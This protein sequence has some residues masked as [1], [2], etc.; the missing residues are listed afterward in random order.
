MV[1]VARLAG[2]RGEPVEGDGGDRVGRRG[3]VVE[4]VLLAGD[5]RLAVLRRR[6]HAAVVG[7]PEAVEED[8]GDG[9]SPRRSSGLAGRLGQAGEGVDERG[10]VGGEGVVAGS[11][12]RRRRA[13]S[14]ASAR[15][16]RAARRA[17]SGRR[18]PRPRST[19][20][21]RAAA[22]ASAS[23][24][25][26]S[27]F[28]SVST[29]SSSP[30]RGRCS[31][32]SNS[33]WRSSS[34]A[35]GR[36]QSPRAWRRLGIERPSKLPSSVMPHQ[37]R[38]ASASARSPSTARDL[39]RRPRVEQALVAVA[40]GSGRVGVLGRREPAGVLAQ[41]AQHVLDGLGDDL[42]PARLIEGDGGV[43]VD[44]HQQRLVVE[45]LLEVRHEPLAIDRVAGEAAAD[46]VVHPAG[47]HRVERRRDDLAQARD[48]P[49]GGGRTAGGR[50]SSSTGTSAP[51][52]T[53]PTRRRTP[54][55]APARCG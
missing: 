44:P 7:I 46:V 55:P 32:A 6:E 54:G 34:I 21:P 16:R 27:A 10:V 3:G 15:R 12:A 43:G 13:T 2:Q 22:P 17:G 11:A 20:A 28:H 33:R 25:T 53:R 18:R 50:G 51:P 19:S 9:A 49:S 24:D 36:A 39:G 30:G 23:D 47:R 48:R 5:E 38:A 8:V 37:A 29:L 1:G 14:G 35:G 4:Q 45:H 52:R 40:V 31:R 41:V 42:A 26:I